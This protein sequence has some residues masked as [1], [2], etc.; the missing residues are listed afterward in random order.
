MTKSFGGIFAG[1][2]QFSMSQK[3]PKGLKDMTLI[4]FETIFNTVFEY[5]F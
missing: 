2:P 4:S 1:I 5:V 3:I